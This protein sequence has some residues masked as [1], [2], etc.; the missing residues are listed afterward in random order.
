MIV[1][2][3]TLSY[4]PAFDVRGNSRLGI[5]PGGRAPLATPRTAA[6]P[7]APPRRPTTRHW[8]RRHSPP[9]RKPFAAGQ[10]AERRW[11]RRPT[12]R[13]MATPPSAGQAAKRDWPRAA[14]A[15]SPAP[16]VPPPRAAGHAARPRAAGF[17]AARPAAGSRLG[18]G[19]PARRDAPPAMRPHGAGH[20]P[21]ASPPPRADGLAARP[22]AA[23]VAATTRRRPRRRA[24][25]RRRCRHHAPTASPP[26]HGPSALPPPRADGL[27]AGPRA[28]GVAA[29]TRRRPRCSATGRRPGW[30]RG[31]GLT[32]ARA[33]RRGHA[34]RHG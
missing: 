14:R 31:A 5:T 16:R 1:S 3:R 6:W 28:A 30:P 9:V 22:R 21:P 25:G 12:T 27:A 19:S 7:R 33:G 13:R 18:H 15:T 34:G 10:A 2:I 11:P 32:A 20:G 4:L 29:T 24:T 17:A 23:G 8:P 26:G